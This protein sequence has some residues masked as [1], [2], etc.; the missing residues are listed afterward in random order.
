MVQVFGKE[1]FRY[2]AN[3]R[4]FQ[5][6][7]SKAF[8][9]K[10]GKDESERICIEIMRRF[11][12]ADET[13]PAFTSNRQH[14]IT[15][16][17]S[18]R[19]VLKELAKQRGFSINCLVREALHSKLLKNAHPVRHQTFKPR[20]VLLCLSPYEERLMYKWCEESQC[21]FNVFLS[22]LASVTQPLL[23]TDLSAEQPRKS[24]CLFPDPLLEEKFLHSVQVYGYLGSAL[25]R[26]ILAFVDRPFD[27]N[28]V[29]DRYLD[30][31]VGGY[32]HALSAK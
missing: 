2:E 24:L 31:L 26:Q 32:A 27:P 14:G 5:P 4:P 1:S 22:T 28:R 3:S 8:I 19:D 23:E 30:W 21:G 6:N 18:V 12:E 10:H 29:Q 16:D 25:F 9:E 13:T 20:S 17:A 11:K 7:V 15:V